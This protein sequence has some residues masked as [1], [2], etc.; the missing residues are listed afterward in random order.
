MPRKARSQGTKMERGQAT[1]VMIYPRLKTKDVFV[2][3][4]TAAGQRMSGFIIL[5]ALK[6]IAREEGCNVD[7]LIPKNEFEELQ[8][9]RGRSVDDFTKAKQISKAMADAKRA[10]ANLSNLLGDKSSE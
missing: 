4:A 6:N 5:N 1:Q 8:R 2:K 7:D 9:V 10:L 3:K